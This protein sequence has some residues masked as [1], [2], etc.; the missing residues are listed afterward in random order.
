MVLAVVVFAAVALLLPATLTSGAV[1]MLV[2][3]VVAGAAVLALDGRPPGALGFHLA[4][5]AGRELAAGLGVGTVVALAV[6]VGMLVLGG[7]RYMGE[8]GS[9]L[10]WLGGGL[11]ALAFLA[12]PA[13][14]EEA[15]L[16]GY[17]LQA[18]AEAWGPA[19][20]L[21][22]TSFAFGG[23]H[24]ANPEVTAL[25]L[26]N[27]AAAGLLLGVV[28]LKTAS[29]WWATGAHLGWNWAH[30]WVAD[31]PVSGLELMDAPF[32]EGVSSG[33]AWLGGG[34]FGPEGSAVATVVVLAA[35]ALLWRS[36][37]LRP[38]EAVRRSR[39]LVLARAVESH[40]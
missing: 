35:S 2:A 12:L 21:G 27:V 28:Y 16:R 1:A 24:L 4:P 30:G 20:A 36:K 29:L 15:V 11:G 40:S 32:Y 37:L 26:T 13:A 5:V 10:G 22:I 8:D 7:V 6:V 34:G 18:L 3:G 14:A 17:P 31:V 9:V 23:L 39:P 19:W 33:P 38:S 25:A